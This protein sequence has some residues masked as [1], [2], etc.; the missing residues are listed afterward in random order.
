LGCGAFGAVTLVRC[1]AS[2]EALALKAVSKGIIIEKRMQRAVMLEKA[3]MQRTCSPFV[4]RL[5]ATFNSSEHLFFLMEAALGGDLCSVYV[6]YGFHG[7]ERHARFYVACMLRAL[8]HLH[9]QGVVYRDI[10]MENVVLD[11]SGYGKLCDFGMAT[12]LSGPEDRAYTVCGTPGYMAPEV[13]EAGHTGY[14]YAADWWSLGVLLYELMTGTSP[15][16]APDAPQI[17]ARVLAGIEVVSFPEGRLWPALVRGLCR[18]SP[19][20]RLPRQPD[21]T[22]LVEEHEWYG[23]EVGF[24]WRAHAA[25]EM[26]APHVPRVNGPID[27]SNFCA[28]WLDRPRDVPYED[29]GT[30]WEEGFEDTFVAGG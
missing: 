25:R 9:G 4:I 14:S 15:F 27:L 19:E 10:K 28:S 6:R 23:E 17:H 21:G 2:G 30:G 11:G 7:S 18:R 5:V 20:E 8:E 3:A 22:R 13:V 26:P 16:A 1:P 12:C 29:P 24:D